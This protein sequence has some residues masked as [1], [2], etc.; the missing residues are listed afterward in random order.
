MPS[1]IQK[2]KPAKKTSRKTSKVAKTAAPQKTVKRTNKGLPGTRMLIPRNR[3]TFHGKSFLYTYINPCH[4]DGMHVAGVPLA[5]PQESAV[6]YSRVDQSVT[7]PAAL[8]TLWGDNATSNDWYVGFF[9]PPWLDDCVFIIAAAHQPTDFRDLAALVHSSNEYP[10]WTASEATPSL[11]TT[12]F[13]CKIANPMIKSKTELETSLHQDFTNFRMIGRGVTTYLPADAL[14][15]RG[16]VTAIQYNAKDSPISVNTSTLLPNTTT[17]V[18]ATANAG[19]AI[20][21]GEVTPKLITASDTQAYQGLARLGC[22]LP[23][24]MDEEDRPFQPAAYRPLHATA[25]KNVAGSIDV[26]VLSQDIDYGININVSGGNCT[27]NIYTKNTND[28]LYTHTVAVSTTAYTNI[29]FYYPDKQQGDVF[30]I[31]AQHTNNTAFISGTVGVDSVF[32]KNVGDASEYRIYIGPSA[33]T[34]DN[35]SFLAG[36]GFRNDLTITRT[37]DN[38]GAVV[39]KIYNQNQNTGIIWYQGISGS[40]PV[41]VKGRMIIEAQAQPGSEWAGFNQPGA[42]EDKYAMSIAAQISHKMNHGYPAACNDQGILS[43]LLKKLLAKVPLV[44]DLLA[45]LV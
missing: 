38:S 18:L 25:D 22:Y 34:T 33:P 20:L 21:F 28:I 27:F 29:D 1:T 10:D 13:Y 31:N 7:A 16:Q 5:V 40:A 35:D 15:N 44:G 2:Q 9:V 12:I 39:D 36:D 42:N 19:K 4:S 30:T 37:L 32:I 3:L 6:V 23:I 14:T 8:V 43:G 17:R 45:G 11:A 26:S 41:R 24:Y